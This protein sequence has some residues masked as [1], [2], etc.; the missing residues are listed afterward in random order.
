MR[1]A[2][3]TGPVSDQA[4]RIGQGPLT[5]PPGPLL[6]KGVFFFRRPDRKETPPAFF[7]PLDFRLA[8][9]HPGVRLHP[10]GAN[11][12]QVKIGQVLPGLTSCIPLGDYY[13]SPLDNIV[14]KAL[15]YQYLVYRVSF[16]RSL[17]KKNTGRDLYAL[18][19]PDVRING[20]DAVIDGHV[21]TTQLRDVG[22]PYI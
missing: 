7:Q 3:Y 20:F 10:R 6:R 13:C 8:R 5:D 22:D 9:G 15:N 11:T 21:L 17:R 2:E 18:D 12:E 14:K 1:S 4:R 19:T 16:L